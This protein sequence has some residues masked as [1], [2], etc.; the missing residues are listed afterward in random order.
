[1]WE[2]SLQPEYFLRDIVVRTEPLIAASRGGF[3]TRPYS[4]RATSGQDTGRFC[5]SSRLLTLNLHPSE[6]DFSGFNQLSARLLNRTSGPLL[7]GMKLIHGSKSFNSETSDVSLS[8]S[9]E[10]LRAGEWFDLKFPAESFGTYGTPDGWRDIR[11]I[12]VS[13]SRERTYEGTEPIDVEI[14][15]LH[16]EFREIP[17]GP[18]LTL[19][20]LAQVLNPDLPG[21]TELPRNKHGFAKLAREVWSPGPPFVADDSGLLIPAPHQYPRECADDIMRGRI[22][23][24]SLGYPF[25]W[26]TCPLGVLEWS[27]FLHRHHFMKEII[28]AWIEKRDERYARELDSLISSWINFNPVPI[29]F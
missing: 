14:Q 12:E 11:E 27:H 2:P 15:S 6:T 20:G 16:G 7:V 21:V 29:G 10:E 3:Q 1:M 18:R 9:R 19:E 17:P 25:P 22:M 24:Q 13:F 23:G 5:S 26:D 4:E 8:G 28:T